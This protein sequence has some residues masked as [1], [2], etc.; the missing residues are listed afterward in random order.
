[1]RT[2]K[3]VLFWVLVAGLLIII[4]AQADGD[5]LK[6]FYFV[7]F[8]MPIAIGTSYFFN[9]FLVPR[10]LLTQQY[11]K[12]VLY[13]FY[14]LIFS[15]YFEMIVLTVSFIVLANYQYDN[16]N[17][18]STNLLLLT[19]TIYL[20]VFIKAFVLILKKYQLKQ[21][22]ISR[23]EEEK[24]KNETK[25]ITIRSDRKSIPIN[26][27][28]IIYIESLADYVKI[29]TQNEQIITKEKI[30]ELDQRLPDSIIRTHRSFLVNKAHIK[31]FNKEEVIT[32]LHTIP[33]SRTYK[34]KVLD[35]LED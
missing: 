32:A 17:P 15:L 6:T 35:L 21:T 4:F 23:M 7:T 2:G 19:F 9:Y 13:L 28:D 11:L 16:L 8:L 5:Y 3:Q 22:T 29:Y 34:K 31:S 27:D 26:L 25:T 1:M 10:F 18:Y 14:T 24:I 30:S 20:I 12:F 33:I